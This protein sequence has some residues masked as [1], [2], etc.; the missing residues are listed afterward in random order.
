VDLDLADE[1]PFYKPP[2]AIRAT[3]YLILLAIVAVIWYS[4]VYN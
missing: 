4:A 2:A 1:P 3:G